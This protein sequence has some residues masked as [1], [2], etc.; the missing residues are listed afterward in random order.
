MCVE[1]G[2]GVLPA[3]LFFANTVDQVNRLVQ[4]LH[5]LT[6]AHLGYLFINLI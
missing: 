2:G 5:Q 6:P 4:L 3:E 1:G